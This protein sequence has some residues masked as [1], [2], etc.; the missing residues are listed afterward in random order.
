MGSGTRQI[1]PFLAEATVAEI[2]DAA[3]EPRVRVVLKAG[4]MLDLPAPSVPDAYLGQ[5]VDLGGFITVE[6]VSPR[7]V[8]VTTDPPA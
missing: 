8:T 4:M 6:F 7:A 2:F 3:G 1:H 5:Q